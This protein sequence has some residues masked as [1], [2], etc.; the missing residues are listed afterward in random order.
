M[1]LLIKSKKNGQF[2]C[3]YDECDHEKVSA[4]KWHVAK[5]GYVA[6]NIRVN[7]KKT[8]MLM[9]RY[10]LGLSNG[11]GVL[12]DHKNWNG[13]DN[14]RENLRV[15]TRT[16]NNRNVK[17]YGKSGRLGVVY[18]KVGNNVYIKAQIMIGGKCLHL[19]NFK[20]EEEA[21]RARDEASKKYH[22]DFASLN[23]K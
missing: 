6:T 21:A 10:L 7:G 17:P 13:L 9:H 18:N 5:S 22:G 11:D 12:A 1:E 23:F 19:G 8:I 20:T 4:H 15:C 14:R 16:E 2:T 3:L